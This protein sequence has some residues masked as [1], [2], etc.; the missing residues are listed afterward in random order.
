MEA[1]NMQPSKCK[2]KVEGYE[3]IFSCLSKIAIHIKI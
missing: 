1:I 2:F 3:Q